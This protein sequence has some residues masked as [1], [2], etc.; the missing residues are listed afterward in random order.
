M[1]HE[2]RG[3]E[4]AGHRCQKGISIWGGGGRYLVIFMVGNEAE[5]STKPRRSYLPTTGIST[6]GQIIQWLVIWM[7]MMLMMII[8]LS[9]TGPVDIDASFGH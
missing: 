8:F 3:N 5:G 1:E 4:S 6:A 9:D 2:G 7:M